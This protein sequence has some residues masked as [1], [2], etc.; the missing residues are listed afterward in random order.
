MVIQS[1][2]LLRGAEWPKVIA[3]YSKLFTQRPN[4]HVFLLAT[5]IGVLFDKRI[6][7]VAE[8]DNGT[9]PS[10]VPRNV[11]NNNSE[12]FDEL[13]QTAVLITATEELSDEQRLELA[14]GEGDKQ[15]DK[16]AFLMSFANFGITKL[17]ELISNDEIESAENLKNF[18]TLSMEGNNLD[19]DPLSFSDIDESDLQ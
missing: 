14:F 11:F 5:T 12:P 13:F 16:R 18:L 15:F 19:L 1:D 10:S 17:A 9:N 2:L 4:Y 6:S 8:E 3:A 7:V